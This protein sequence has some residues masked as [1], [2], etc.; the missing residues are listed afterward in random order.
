[1]I[2][3]KCY[4]DDEDI[5]LDKVGSKSYKATYTPDDTNNFN[6]VTG[7][8]I[9]VDVSEP[10]SEPTPS[11]KPESTYIPI[12]TPSEVKPSEDNKKES[13]PRALPYTIE[14]TVT[15]KDSSVTNKITEYHEDGSITET[16]IIEWKSDS[17]NGY[18]YGDN[19]SNSGKESD[20]EKS[21][22]IKKRVGMR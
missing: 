22:I 15:N 11:Q 12:Y 6:I 18:N 9:S 4:I 7:I 21:K 14:N 13:T 8:E 5:I 17:V 10:E 1:M 2:I 3:I 16:V 19:D 20:T